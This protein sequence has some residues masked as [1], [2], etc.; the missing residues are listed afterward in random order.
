MTKLSNL[1]T[2]FVKDED[3]V[4]LTEYLV[5]LGLITAAVITAILLFGNNL[6]TSFDEWADWIAAKTGSPVA[7]G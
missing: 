6:A 4:A 7:G 1:V 2:R 5:L 3:G